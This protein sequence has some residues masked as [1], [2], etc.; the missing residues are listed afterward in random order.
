MTEY[1]Q[2]LFF[3]RATIFVDHCFQPAVMETSLRSRTAAGLLQHGCTDAETVAAVY[4]LVR[5]DAG[6]AAEG[7]DVSVALALQ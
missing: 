2:S 1:L 3:L 4:E 6:L 7:V 5:T